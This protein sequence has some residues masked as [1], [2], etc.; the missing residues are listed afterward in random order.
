MS[1]KRW[2]SEK[3]EFLELE[4]PFYLESG[5]ALPQV[6]I[7]YRTWGRPRPRATL[8]CHA[9]TGSADADDWWGDLFGPGKALDPI[10]HEFLAM[11][12]SKKG[13]EVVVKDGYL[14]VPAS[15]AREE[16]ATVGIEPYF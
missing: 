11:V 12:L 8:V 9:L 6:R 2:I 16:L 10:T 13:Q 7:A 15:V 1:L 3:T 4:G 5:S 14:P